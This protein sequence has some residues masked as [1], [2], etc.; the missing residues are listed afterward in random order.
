MV[1]RLP[2]F[3]SWSIWAIISFILATPCVAGAVGQQHLPGQFVWSGEQ[4]T[5]IDC[6][7][8]G[9]P[10]VVLEAGLGGFSVEWQQ[11][12]T[13]L[14]SHARVCTYDRPGY[15]YSGDPVVMP[16]T[17]EQIAHELRRL[18][19]MAGE[20]PPYLLAGHSFGG[21]V[22]QYFAGFYPDETAGLALID[23]A[24]PEQFQKLE[25]Q[26]SSTR[27]APQSGRRFVLFNA[28]QVPAALAEPQR[29]EAQALM[30]SRRPMALYSELSNFRASAAGLQKVLAH[31][32]QR[33]ALVISRARPDADI[34]GRT[35]RREFVWDSLQE[36][37]A[38]RL[39][40]ERRVSMQGDH[41]LHLTDPELVVS[42]LSDMLLSLRRPA[43]E[44]NLT[45]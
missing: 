20:K 21:L 3:S 15:G 42:G 25:S 44:P 4:K 37:L 13:A 26:V 2:Y 27:L 7:G 43:I 41:H 18:L 29:S 30:S 5:H 14:A 12:Q 9:S 24:T 31:M 38:R 34:T 28:Q 39:H 1:F 45:N 32:P 19:H 11:V 8:A 36:G 6:R 23:S 17:A 40:A 35:R 10:T 22:V 33:P 16:R